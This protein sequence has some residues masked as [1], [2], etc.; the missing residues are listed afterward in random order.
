MNRPISTRMHG[1]IDYAFA[2]ALIGLPYALG[3]NG[4]AAKLSIGS[5]LA[6]LGMSMLTR[7]ELGVVPL[8][9]MKAH[10]SMDAA[11]SSML[12]SAPRMLRGSDP[13][14]GRVLALLGAVGAAVGSMT[15]TRAP[16]ELARQ[17]R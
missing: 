13:A 2:A 9:P 7:Y 11:E 14:P 15:Q 5:G 16:R 3:W 17:Y 6:T 4:R 12:M 8:I 1:M 10:L